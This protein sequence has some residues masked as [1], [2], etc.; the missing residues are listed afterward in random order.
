MNQW[1][2]DGEN[3]AGQSIRAP[4]VTP[5]V[6]VPSINLSL[7]VHRTWTISDAA[8]PTRGVFHG[9]VPLC[10]SANTHL[11]LLDGKALQMF[12]ARGKRCHVSAA[13]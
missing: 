6:Q 2:W 13:V 3:P 9:A 7:M 8:R 4:V 5:G 12:S 10:P 1:E 11:I